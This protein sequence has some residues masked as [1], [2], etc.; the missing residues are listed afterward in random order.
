MRGSSILCLFVLT[1]AAACGGD[2]ISVD[3][4]ESKLVNAICTNRVGCKSMPDLATCKA[5]TLVKDKEFATTLAK[6]KAGTIKFDGDK[7]ADCIDSIASG[8]CSFDGF[9]PTATNACDAVFTGTVATNGACVVSE[10][11]AGESSCEPTDQACNS[12]TTC[13]PGT[14]MAIPAKVAV[15][16]DCTNAD[17]V[18]TAY[19]SSDTNKCTAPSTTAGSAC[20]D[21][22][23]CAN[24]M[25]CDIFAAA[26]TCVAPAAGGA[27]CTPDALLP[28]SDF[29]EYCDATTMKCTPVVA[30]GQ[31]CEGAN[32][33][34]CVGYADCT[35]MTC[36]ARPAAGGS[37]LYDT[38]SMRDNCLGDT[39]CTANATP[40]TLPTAGTACPRLGGSSTPALQP[41]RKVRDARL[42]V[43]KHGPA[44]DWIP[45]VQPFK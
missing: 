24:P 9:Y 35:N 3:D 11:C 40:C 27:S 6:A 26:P 23:A 8:S 7:A 45:D 2:S 19:C 22:D 13:C 17:C 29:R 31:A 1:A 34:E 4:F 36:V 33:A 43:P 5:A 14:C 30:V 37:C 32:G 18:D 44:I 10:E 38:Q 39:S 15:G 41:T 20:S 12:D 16:G 25:Y 21:I 28:C 42:N